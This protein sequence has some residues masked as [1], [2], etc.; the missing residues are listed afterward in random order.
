VKQSK[1]FSGYAEFNAALDDIENC[2]PKVYRR[3][4]QENDNKE[5]SL[6]QLRELVNIERGKT[7]DNRDKSINL[8]SFIEE[9][10]E[11]SYNRMNSNTGKF[12]TPTT[13]RAY[14]QSF[15]ILKEFS[16]Y[17][18]RKF[19]FEDITTDFYNE[20]TKFMNNKLGLRLN[21]IG[22]HQRN[23][24]TF[25]K[26]AFEKKLTDN[27]D[28]MSR[29]FKVTSEKVDDVYL[30]ENEIELL[31]Q[32]DL[33]NNKKLSRVRDLFVLGCNTG[34]RFSDLSKLTRD[35]I[36]EQK[37]KFDLVVTTQKTDAKV[38]I[39]LLKNSLQITNKYLE[40]TGDPFPKAYSNQKMN[41]YLKE[42][43]QMIPEFHK[44]FVTTNFIKGKKNYCKN[45]KVC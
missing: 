13:I 41:Q 28:F 4:K 38:K 20:F 42:V 1:E 26:E 21:T 44:D 19:D 43:C 18:S 8:F 37:G 6:L 11:K 7:E 31:Q 45:S 12:I 24:K 14:K 27:R 10:L 9:F 39:P 5:P 32:L 15:R 33:N 36:V 2:I 35:N 30:D 34:L 23:I 25:M 17:K 16:K 29:T 22:K 40:E 3:F